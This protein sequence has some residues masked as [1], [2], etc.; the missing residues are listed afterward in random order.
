MQRGA[1]FAIFDVPHV[2]PSEGIRNVVKP[3]LFYYFQNEGDAGGG[4]RMNPEEQNLQNMS[5][6]LVFC[7]IALGAL[8]RPLGVVSFWR[9][10]L[11]CSDAPKKV[12]NMLK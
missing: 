7:A 10:C 6:K 1:R 2:G 4:H 11:G 5:G 8:W 3:M 9:P 12:K